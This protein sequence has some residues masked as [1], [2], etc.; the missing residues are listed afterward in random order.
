MLVL[1][2][3]GCTGPS[4]GDSTGH[5]ADTAPGVG[6]ADVQPRNDLR[7]EHGVEWIRSEQLGEREIRVHFLMGNPNCYGVRA[8]VRET[9]EAVE[10]RVFEG[11]LPGAPE[12]CSL[13]AA[14]ASLLVS[15]DAPVAG[16]R[17]TQP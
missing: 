17:I 5:P 12:N 11:R 1:V 9:A 8:Q 16:R 10:I 13:N 15:T 7:A 4:S 6:T 2:L 14:E 3:L